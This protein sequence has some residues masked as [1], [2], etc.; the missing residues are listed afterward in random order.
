MSKLKTFGFN[1][2]DLDKDNLDTKSIF[3]KEDESRMRKELKIKKVKKINFDK[4]FPS[5]KI[6]KCMGLCNLSDENDPFKELL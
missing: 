4:I 5:P 2:I 1:F 6:D 3:N